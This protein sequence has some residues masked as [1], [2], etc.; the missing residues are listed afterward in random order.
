MKEIIE[1][2]SKIDAIAYENEQKVK[3]ILVK[4]RKRFE[5][6]M[7]KYRDKTLAD[8]EKK[9]KALYDQIKS[10]TDDECHKNEDMIKRY[11]YKLKTNYQAAEDK[12]VREIV[13]RLI[14]R[15]Q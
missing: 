8:A 4:E 5:D 10:K 11:A 1:H 12:I 13:A 3:R 9:A 14:E 2:I 15:E 6:E 7:K